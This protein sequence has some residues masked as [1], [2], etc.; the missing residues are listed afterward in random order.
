MQCQVSLHAFCAMLKSVAMQLWLS[1]HDSTGSMRACS[2]LFIILLASKCT[3]RLSIL[4]Q[5]ILCL[6]SS[7]PFSLLQCASQLR[8]AMLLWWHSAAKHAQPCLLQ[9]IYMICVCIRQHSN[10]WHPAAVRGPCVTRASLKTHL[11]ICLLSCQVVNH[12]DF[13]VAC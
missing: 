4:L 5:H 12:F 11:V 9:C 2:V 7:F 10:R 13:T 1:A 6:V 3:R 8:Q